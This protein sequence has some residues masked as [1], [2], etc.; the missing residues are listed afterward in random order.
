[1]IYISK[2]CRLTKMHMK[3]V[4]FFLHLDRTWHTGPKWLFSLILRGWKKWQ[5]KFSSWSALNYLRTS[6]VKDVKAKNIRYSSKNKCKQ[7]FQLT[8]FNHKRW[9]ELEKR[10][11][12]TC[13]CLTRPWTCSTWV[14][15]LLQQKN[16]SFLS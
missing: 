7:S 16:L 8:E 6:T 5:S 9:I 13:V 4:I 3:S 1:M 14:V 15:T 12:R 10:G 11:K 2:N